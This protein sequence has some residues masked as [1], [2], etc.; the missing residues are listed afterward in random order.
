MKPARPRRRL[1]TCTS[2]ARE[3]VPQLV[4]A[5][6]RA[7]TARS[8]RPSATR[9]AL[10]VVSLHAVALE[11]ENEVGQ[12]TQRSCRGHQ[13]LESLAQPEVPGVEHDEP[14]GQPVGLG[15]WVLLRLRHQAWRDPPS[16]GSP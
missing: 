4:P 2:A 3:R 7:G 9:L 12:V 16:C 15:E 10:E 5:T 14:V 6:R 1:T 8:S 13:M 11:D